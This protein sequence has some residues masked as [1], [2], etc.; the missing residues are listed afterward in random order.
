MS[1][2]TSTMLFAQR[3][4]DGRWQMAD[5]EDAVRTCYRVDVTLSAHHEHRHLQ[6]PLLSSL[7]FELG[8]WDKIE[9]Y[10]EVREGRPALR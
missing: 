7:A 2:S 6:P 5:R 9:A 8:R 4:A 3:M 10:L 1:V